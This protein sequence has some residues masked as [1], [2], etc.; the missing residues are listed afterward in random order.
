MMR[1]QML[2]SDKPT[3]VFA[4]GAGQV[5][6]AFEIV[7]LRYGLDEAEFR[8]RPHTYT[9]INTNS[10][11]ILDIPMCQGLIDFAAAGQINIITPFTLSGAM[12]PVTIPGALVPAARRDAVRSGADPDGPSRGAGGVR[13]LYLEC[14]HEVRRARVRH[15]GVRARVLGHRAARAARRTALALVGVV[16]LQRAGRAGHMGDADV[17]VGR[18]DRRG[19]HRDPRRRLAGGRAERV[20]R[21]VHPRHRAAPAHGRTHAAGALGRRRARARRHAGG[22]VPAGTSSEPGTR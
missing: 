3:F 12:A 22:S 19:Q 6:D 9:V 17:A 10:P 4:R 15:A 7:R 11:L 18:A 20:L 21:E 5:T 8:A 2:D 14:R 16:R 1:V 13:R